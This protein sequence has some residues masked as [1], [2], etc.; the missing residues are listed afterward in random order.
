MWMLC[1]RRNANSSRPAPTVLLLTRSMK[2]NPPVSRLSLYTSKATG[3]SSERLHTPISFRAS[4]LAA[5]CS[6][7]LTL[8]LYL[9]SPICALTVR[10]PILRRYGRP[11]SIG[12]SAIQMIVASNW[13][14]TSAGADAVEITSP[15][16]MSISSTKVRV[17]DWPAIASLRS[18]SAVTMRAVLSRPEGCTRTRSPVWTVPLA[19]VPA[20]PRKS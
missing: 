6:S 15:R 4:V 19:T 17:I 8:T 1:A 7:E 16:E 9:R 2:M 14:A 10:A 3:W 12:S 13:S 11:G 5:T 18:P 20:K